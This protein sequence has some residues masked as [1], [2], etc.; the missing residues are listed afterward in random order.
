MFCKRAAA[1]QTT[2]A[3]LGQAE[4][5]LSGAMRARPQTH[6]PEAVTVRF[7]QFS[8]PG[9]DLRRPDRCLQKSQVPSSRV[10]IGR[11]M[12]YVSSQLCIH[13]AHVAP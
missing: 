9:Q 10:W 4:F 6:T 11:L 1:V 7:F 2:T 8:S 5:L 12:V 13:R 3:E